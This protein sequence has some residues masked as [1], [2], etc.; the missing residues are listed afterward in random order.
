MVPTLGRRRGVNAQTFSLRRCRRVLHGTGSGANHCAA[1]SGRPRRIFD[2]GRDWWGTT[3]DSTSAS[4]STLRAKKPRRGGTRKLGGVGG[5]RHHRGRHTGL[6]QD[7]VVGHRAD[8]LLSLGGISGRRNRGAGRNGRR[9]D[10]QRQTRG[11]RLASVA[12][13]ARGPHGGRFRHCAFGHR[14]AQNLAGAVYPPLL[15]RTDGVLSRFVFPERIRPKECLHSPLR[16][17]QSGHYAQR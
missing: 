14:D 3:S 1:R 7:E 16:V 2:S 9:A 8:R 11:P 15:G 13:A 12:A 5:W 17:F 4:A 10:A 6:H